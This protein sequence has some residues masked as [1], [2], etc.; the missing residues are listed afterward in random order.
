VKVKESGHSYALDNIK[1]KG[2]T[3]LQFYKDP[4][5]NGGTVAVGT[6]CQE[7]IRAL[8]DRVQFLEKQ[9][10]WQGNEE[11][12]THLRAALA[13]FES[14]AI[15]RKVEKGLPIETLPVG[16]DGHLILAEETSDVCS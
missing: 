6:N 8:I 16:L 14:R 11:I 7:V 2:T 1:L 15:Q 10:H 9:K 12:I 3:T 4:D 5:I 13:L